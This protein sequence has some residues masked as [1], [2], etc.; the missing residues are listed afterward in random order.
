MHQQVQVNAHN[1]THTLPVHVTGVSVTHTSAAHDGVRTSCARARERMRSC[2]HEHAHVRMHVRTYARVQ[3]RFPPGS[4][5]NGPEAV[6]L[7]SAARMRV[8]RTRDGAPTY[9]GEA[10]H[11]ALA[12][13]HTRNE[14]RATRARDA[15]AKAKQVGQHRAGVAP[16]PA[17]A[18]QPWTPLVGAVLGGRWPTGGSARPEAE[19]PISRTCGGGQ[20]LDMGHR[21]VR[22]PPQSTAFLPFPVDRAGMA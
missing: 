2:T 20:A 16:E 22:L 19:A 3:G 10:R 21:K 5:R 13:A 4:V 7:T 12:H 14:A 15:S 11:N 1:R 18:H 9:A 6:P 8:H 17:Q